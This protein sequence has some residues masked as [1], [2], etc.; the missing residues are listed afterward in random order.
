MK[1]FFTLIAVAAMSTTMWAI[2]APTAQIQ[3]TKVNQPVPV[4]YNFERAMK[5]APAKMQMGVPQEAVCPAQ[6]Y[7]NI[8]TA[9]KAAMGDDMYAFYLRP[10]GTLNCGI[11][12][13][14]S[15]I[16]VNYP[17]IVGSWL[18]DVYAWK[19]RN[20]SKGYT[21]IEYQNAF[22][23]AYPQYAKEGNTIDENGNW[24]DSLPANYQFDAN[25]YY[26][27]RVPLQIVS[28]GLRKDSFVTNSEYSGRLD[29]IIDAMWTVSGAK[30]CDA[31]HE[32][33]EFSGI[34]YW[35]LTN[36]SFYDYD[37]GFGLM[38]VWET[39]K[40][41]Q[42]VEYVM[43]SSTVTTMNKD[44]QEVVYKPATIIQYFEKPMSPLYIHDVTL[45]I[46]AVTFKEDKFYYTKPV[47]DSLLM[48]ITDTT[49]K[50]VFAVSLATIK[51]TTN[52]QYVPGSMVHFK[53]EKTD[54]FGGKEIGVT[55]NEPFLVMIQGLNR[56][57]N[58]FG[59]YC[60]IDLH[61]GG[62]TIVLDAN[63][64]KFVN[65]VKADAFIQLNSLYYT[66]EDGTRAFGYEPRDSNVINIRL[67]YDSEDNS[68]YAVCNDGEM[69]DYVPIVA[70]MDLLYDTITYNYNYDIDAPDWADLDMAYKTVVSGD[71]STA[72]DF[73]CYFLYISYYPEDGAE[74]VPAVGDEI[75]LHKYGKE[76]IYRVVESPFTD[77][78]EHTVG[79]K[80]SKYF[81]GKQIIIRKGD[82]RMNVLGAE[83]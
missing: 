19:W 34:E 1:K 22:G 7:E 66:L 63:T 26:S 3:R 65:Y 13:Q 78:N 83:L 82:K 11:D 74:E 55:L 60:G 70:S 41:S 62:N 5:Q 4:Q 61:T 77:L 75:K 59:I 69:E 51:D 68:Y 10:E 52:M 16:F 35:P 29:T 58:E 72:W 30:F 28:N 45:P 36:A 48:I 33:E 21:K 56:P 64:Q 32:F 53:I 76:I 39:Y 50:K 25:S 31:M 67:E 24:I 47:F 2:S 14:G 81:D 44:S 57:G 8:R 80:V 12:P 46:N 73:G 43:G 17:A 71:G 49:M 15:Y 27:Y 23:N 18:N 42:K 6:S 40:E 37:F 20:Y 54:E 9:R 38:E 79:A